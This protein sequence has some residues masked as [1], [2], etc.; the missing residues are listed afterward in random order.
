MN[1]IKGVVIVVLLSLCF[2][3]AAV[4]SEE[5]DVGIS[6]GTSPTE[7]VKPRP[8]PDNVLPLTSTKSYEPTGRL[9]QTGEKGQSKFMQLIG[10]LCLV[11][12]FWMFLFIR[13]KD[14]DEEDEGYEYQ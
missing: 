11:G 1:R 10:A 12:V 9:P 8:E 7:P 6:F 4:A 14:E 13:F 3:S 2:S 5:T